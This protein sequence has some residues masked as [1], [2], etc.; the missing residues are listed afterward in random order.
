MIKDVMVHLDGG[1]EDEIRIAY[2]EALALTGPAHVTGLYTNVLPDYALALPIDAGA[3]A[4]QVL[5]DAEQEVRGAGE[6]MHRRLQERFARLAV[7]N[8]VR[9]L[10]QSSGLI[11][12]LVA[13]EALCADIF[14]ATRP[15]ATDATNVWAHLVQSVLF[16]SGR[17]L[18]LVPPGTPPRGPIRT[19]LL[20]WQDSREPARALREGLPFIEQAARTIAV[21]VDP[22]TAEEAE[23]EADLL[24]HLSRHTAAAEAV[25][26]AAG[27][28]STAEA[29][30]DE[31]R[32]V[33][34]DLVVMGG[35]GHSRFSE[36]IMGGVTVD[37]LTFCPYPILMA[38]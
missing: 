35:Y 30:V 19:V 20:A 15:Y 2:A 32:R 4:A 3:A 8:E 23:P 16:G 38:H 25:S 36:W 34:A 18:L 31:A 24:R 17:A 26:I 27:E 37:M 29:L 33:S 6:A 9:L 22:D 21:L 14:V 10:Q 11:A 13:R 28:R 7:T 12:S 1:P 5:A